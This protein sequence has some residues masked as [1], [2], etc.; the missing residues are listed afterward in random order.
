MMGVVEVRVRGEVGGTG[1]GKSA[2]LKVRKRA[3]SLTTSS[4]EQ[5]SRQVFANRCS[6]GV[7][8][9]SLDVEVVWVYRFVANVGET[10]I[11]SS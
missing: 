6:G 10:W 5:T 1:E 3:P 8:R 2:G 7:K 9:G 4:R 11:V